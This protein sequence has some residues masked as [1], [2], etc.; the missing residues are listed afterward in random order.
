MQSLPGDTVAA[1]AAGR[2]WPC[3]WGGPLGV[4]V[5]RNQPE[6]FCVEEVAKTH[7]AGVGEHTWLLI[8][9]RGANT[10]FVARELAKQL[11]VRL[12][13]VGFAGRKDRNAVATQWF[14]VPTALKNVDN[15]GTTEWRVLEHGR[16]LRKIK[17][18]YLVGNRFRIRARDF[19][20]DHGLVESR[21][22]E[23]ARHGV[24][25]YFGPQRF[26]RAGSNLL[27]A[28]KLAGRQR[29]SKERRSLAL[30]AARSFIFNEILAKRVAAGSWARIG[31]GDVVSLAGSGSVFSVD[32]I[33]DALLERLQQGDIHPTVPLWG[34]GDLMTTGAARALEN[35]VA[36]RYPRLNQVSMSVAASRRAARLL[37]KS[38]SVD[39]E[40]RDTVV[41]H[42][43]LGKGEFATSVLREIMDGPELRSTLPPGLAE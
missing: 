39:F 10:G 26:G 40:S 37:P 4:A 23:I 13:D 24:P 19:T 7:P 21:V 41:F 8:Q 38:M 22:A 18:G 16:S 43:E 33:D 6:D 20:V 1:G 14:S 2:R 27:D 3:A 28:L 12:R 29:L 17:R 5:L 11:G 36:E 42:F 35:E 9:K 31:V 30:S 32:R 15:L 25:N 34:R